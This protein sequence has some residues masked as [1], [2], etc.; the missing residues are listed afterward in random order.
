MDR[1]HGQTGGLSELEPQSDQANAT[2][3]EMAQ[4]HESPR[5]DVEDE[6]REALMRQQFDRDAE[7]W[8]QSVPAEE[9]LA[10]LEAK[11]KPTK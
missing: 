7:A 11:I 2:I 8:D 1:V 6:A 3:E 5:T 4:A 9:V 10:K